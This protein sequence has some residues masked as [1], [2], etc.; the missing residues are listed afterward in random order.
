MAG[1]DGPFVP[2]GPPRLSAL[3]R[4]LKEAMDQLPDSALV[5]LAK[6]GDQQAFADLYTRWFD[7][8]YD[9]AARMMRNRDEAADVAQD[10]F[11]RAMNALGGLQKGASF[12]SWI[13]TIAR[14]TALNRIQK[15]GRTRPLAYEGDDGEEFSLDVVDTDRFGSPEEAAEANAVA[16]PSGKLRQGSIPGNSPSSISTCARGSIVRRLRTSSASRRTT[17][18]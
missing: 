16:S 7:P 1:N 3:A 4:L 12:K 8:V 2:R 17:L 6:A 15:S 10:T 14:N 11:L 9:F 13:F 18:T 5:E